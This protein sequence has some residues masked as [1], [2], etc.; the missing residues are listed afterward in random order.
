MAFLVTLLIV[1]WISI[2]L[3]GQRAVDVL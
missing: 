1:R 3:E 2:F